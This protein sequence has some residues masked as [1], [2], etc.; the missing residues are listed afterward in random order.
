MNQAP[1]AA[2]PEPDPAVSEQI[3]ST[4]N[5]DLRFP[6]VEARLSQWMT[7][8]E[9]RFLEPALTIAQRVRLSGYPE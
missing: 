7:S 8:A 9:A 2:E 5:D 6:K 3:E 4:G 1:V